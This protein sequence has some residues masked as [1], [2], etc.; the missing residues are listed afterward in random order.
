MCEPLKYIA[1]SAALAFASF[2]TG[3]HGELRQ[4]QVDEQTS[5]DGAVLAAAKVARRAMSPTVRASLMRASDTQAT[6]YLEGKAKALPPGEVRVAR[7]HWRVLA[8]G[9]VVIGRRYAEDVVAGLRDSSSLIS[10]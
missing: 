7:G 9:D 4:G 5:P 10:L 1:T 3:G 6:L 2:L 8:C